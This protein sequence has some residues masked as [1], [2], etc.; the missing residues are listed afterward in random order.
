MLGIGSPTH[1]TQAPC[2]AL[3]CVHALTDLDGLLNLSKG[4]V[5]ISEGVNL[6]KGGE[7]SRFFKLR[8]NAQIDYK[9][10]SHQ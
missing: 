2:S 1:D 3:D 4:F 9:K 7:N 10:D 6:V 5:G 8:Q